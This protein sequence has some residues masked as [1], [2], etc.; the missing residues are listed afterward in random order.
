MSDFRL[1]ELKKESLDRIERLNSVVQKWKCNHCN[2]DDR[3]QVSE[4]NDDG[5]ITKALRRHGYESPPIKPLFMTRKCSEEINNE[6][7]L[8]LATLNLNNRDKCEKFLLLHQIHVAKDLY[9]RRAKLTTNLVGRINDTEAAL[10]S[11]AKRRVEVRRLIREA[12]SNA[13]KCY[14][15]LGSTMEKQRSLITDF[16]SYLELIEE[17]TDRIKVYAREGF[18]ADQQKCQLLMENQRLNEGSFQDLHQ[19]EIDEMHRQMSI[20]E[21][22]MARSPREKRKYL[23]RLGWQ[24][25][26]L[27]F[28]PVSKEKALL[29]SDV[30]IL[31]AKLTILK[32]DVAFMQDRF[33]KMTYSEDPYSSEITL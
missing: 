8:F 1:E 29:Q 17:E 31:E 3:L 12:Q 2:P 15:E 27:K 23:N 30:I 28:K 20:I 6:V 7:K 24:I 19:T 32:N 10:G 33:I 14:K 5:E 26:N 25:R 18:L 22:D 9:D 4:D 13:E 16:D 11:N 21:I